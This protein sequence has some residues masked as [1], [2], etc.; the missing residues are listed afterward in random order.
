LETE[1]KDVLFYSFNK[2]KNIKLAKHLN[3]YEVP[4]FI[5]YKN[6]DEITRLVNKNRKSYQEVREF[7]L[8][9]IN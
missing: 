2:D 7:I 8:E 9:S 3:I 6:G 4:S 1:F 5:I